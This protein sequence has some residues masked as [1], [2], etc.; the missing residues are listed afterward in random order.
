MSIEIVINQIF[1]FYWLTRSRVD[2]DYVYFTDA[3]SITA[4][5]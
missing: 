2:E 4:V 1:F 5:Q 3:T